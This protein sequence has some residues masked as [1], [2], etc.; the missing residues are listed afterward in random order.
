MTIPSVAH[1]TWQTNGNPVCAAA[2]VQSAPVAIADGAGGV[3]VAWLDQRPVSPGIYAQHVLTDGTTGW[4]ANGVLLSGA[5]VANPPRIMSDAAGGALIVWPTGPA[6]YAQRVDGNGVIHSGW[7]VDGRLI[8]SDVTSTANF[9]AVTDGAGG[10]YFTRDK[11]V[12]GGFNTHFIRLTRIDADGNFVAGWTESGV[13]VDQGDQASLLDLAADP[14]GGALTGT[15]SFIEQGTNPHYGR[16]KRIRPNAT[17]AYDVGCT[18]LFPG[19]ASQGIFHIASASDGSGG[20]YWTYQSVGGT[21]TSYFGQHVDAAGNALWSSTYA[22]PFSELTVEDGTVAVWYVGRP[23]GTNR[24]EVHRRDPAGAL[25][26]GWTSAGV[27]VSQPATLGGVAAKT[28]PTVVVLCWS[29]N[30]TGSGF[31]IRA[32]SVRQDAVIPPGWDPGGS[33]V[34]TA[35]GD[36]KSPALVLEGAGA[37]GCWEDQR[38]G[39]SNQDIYANRIEPATAASVGPIEM[40]VFGIANVAPVPASD[41]VTVTYSRTDESPV[42]LEVT[43]VTGRIVIRREAGAGENR[44]DFELAGFVSGVY[45]VRAT[46]GG[47]TV[48]ARFAVVR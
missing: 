23:A 39:A 22:V 20:A 7:P 18:I 14:T 21:G 29:E 24:L 42:L 1:A 8:T 17:I 28:F 41:R 10:V 37:I 45:F 15:N 36:Q 13:Q 48:R 32:L 3:F 11:F 47:R 9:G 40:P 34:C 25:P 35:A 2:G 38:A 6:I 27:V 46:Q 30:T 5:T 44:Q 12:T 4:A 33:P 31:A 19:A 16:L 43:D 26:A